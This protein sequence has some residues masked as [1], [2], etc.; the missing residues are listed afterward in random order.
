MPKPQDVIKLPAILGMVQYYAKFL[1]N[2]AT[3]PTPAPSVITEQRE[4]VMRNRVRHLFPGRGRYVVTRHGSDNLW[5]RTAFSY[6]QRQLL[7]WSRSC[8]IT[9]YITGKRTDHAYPTRSLSEIEEKYS[10]IMRSFGPE[11]NSQ[12][13]FYGGAMFLSSV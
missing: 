12:R 11:K 7:V 6:S 2:L 3:H 9:P 10:Q 13:S 4:V 8:L 1:A 5:P